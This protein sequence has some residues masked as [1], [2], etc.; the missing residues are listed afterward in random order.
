MSSGMVGHLLAWEKHEVD[1][2]EAQVHLALALDRRAL[3]TPVGV[4]LAAVHP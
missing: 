2:A 3:G 1:A 4:V